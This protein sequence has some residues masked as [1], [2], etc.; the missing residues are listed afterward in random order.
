MAK[1]K[2]LKVSKIVGSGSLAVGPSMSKLEADEFAKV[3]AELVE[4]GET[5]KNLAAALKDADLLLYGGVPFTDAMLKAAPNASP[6][7][8]RPLAMMPLT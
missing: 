6:C 4:V 3:N 2:I 5:D 1:F 7:Y 8:S